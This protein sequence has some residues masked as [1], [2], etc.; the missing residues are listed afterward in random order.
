MVFS[1]LKK[2]KRKDPVSI[3]LMRTSPELMGAIYIYG[4]IG[5]GKTATLLSFAEIYHDHP[6]RRYKIFDL[7][8]GSRN[9]H[10]YWALPSNK[11][12]YWKNVKKMFRLDSEGIKQYKVNLLYPLTSNLPSNLPFNPPHVFSKIF[13]I[14][15]RSLDTI[16]LS[17][18]LGTLSLRTE[19]LW[20]E[21][22]YKAK[23]NISIPKLIK[24]VE[25]NGGKNTSLYRNFLIPLA[26]E[27]FIQE[28]SCQFNIDLKK[29]LFDKETIS[30]LCLDFV[31]EEYRLFILRYF[32]N[33]IAK[34]LD[35][36]GQK[37]NTL[38]PM[39]EASDFFRVTDQTI[40][41]ERKKIF[42]AELASYIKMGRRGM[43]L[44]LDTQSPCL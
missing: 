34:V 6:Q 18:V 44:V 32:L 20:G 1:G 33:N 42:K 2:I 29:E 16:D 15:F 9:E 22:K 11:T 25:D 35:A 36:S 38:L 3:S 28:D 23:K 31:K 27:L 12:L 40:V 14:P 10:L 13:T 26:R 39:R 30:V 7:W 41:P 5:C 37:R 4:R 21:V 43:H 8:G 19:S 17:L 24:L